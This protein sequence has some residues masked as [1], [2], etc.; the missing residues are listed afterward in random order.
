MI[1]TAEYLGSHESA[2]NSVFPF[3]YTTVSEGR[4]MVK[5]VQFNFE[6]WGGGGVRGGGEGVNKVAK[7]T[8][9]V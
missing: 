9:D 3:I 5:Q 7:Q 1:T 8:Q 4:S 2:K 6:R